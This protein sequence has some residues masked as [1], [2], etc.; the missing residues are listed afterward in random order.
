M[1]NEEGWKIYTAEPLW[2]KD[3]EDVYRHYQDRNA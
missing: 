2:E 3:G 1:L